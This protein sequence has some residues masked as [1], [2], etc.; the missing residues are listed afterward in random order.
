[1]KL[2]HFNLIS[3][4]GAV[5]AGGVFDAFPVS[6]HANKSP[7]IAMTVGGLGVGVLPVTVHAKKFPLVALLAAGVGISTLPVPVHAGDSKC[8][9]GDYGCGKGIG[10]EPYWTESCA[11]S[12]CCCKREDYDKYRQ[13]TCK[14]YESETKG[15]DSCLG[16]D[17]CE[18]VASTV[19]IGDQSCV[20]DY[21]CRYM[22]GNSII[23]N[24]SCRAKS[25]CVSTSNVVIGTNSCGIGQ[26][27][28]FRA[29]YEIQNS[30]VG[31]NS[32]Q[33][34]SSCAF[35][36]ESGGYGAYLSIGDNACNLDSTCMECASGSKVPNGACST[37]G[38]DDVQS[39]SC[40]LTNG[41]ILDYDQCKYCIFTW[42][43]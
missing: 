22:K 34:D 28:G 11:A 15:C 7:L 21:S 1:M 19:K 23:W 31:S 9:R 40:D 42:I 2:Q 41:G 37:S 38:A 24:H 25:A 3:I 35:Y 5:V 17:A 30:N 16:Q 6:V 18:N 26:T 13:D 39:V 32:C 36:D 29:C 27:A 20:N 12:R 14:G 33:N 10:T 8:T 43:C 4:I